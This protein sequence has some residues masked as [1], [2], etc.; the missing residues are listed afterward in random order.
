[1]HRKKIALI[2]GGQVGST[3]ALLVT[4]K[5]L[6]NTVIIDLPQY[7]NQVKGKALDIM[8]LRPHDAYDVNLS[9]TSNYAEI[10]GADVVVVTAGIPRTPQMNRKDLLSVNLK[11]IKKVATQV[12][13]YTPEAFVVIATNPVDAMTHAF[14][15]FS[16]FPKQ[17]VIGL[18]GALDTGR[19]QNF[20]A[21]ETGISV[22]DVSCLVMGGHGPTMVPIVRTATVGGIP[23]T[24]LLS[25]EKIAALVKRTREAGTEIVNLLGTGSAYFSS[26]A[27]ITEMVEAHMLDKKRVIASS[28][29]CEGEYGV[30][31][32][33]IGVPCVIGAHG[34]E[35][36]IE[37]KL[38]DDESK[39]FYQDLESIKE[40]IAE[41]QL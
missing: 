29:L 34:V 19:F 1:M 37:F 10:I 4:Q 23:L 6:G 24:D 31:G 13:K 27:S 40:T 35:R 3:V 33:F 21:M 28:V 18:S 38:A 26:A 5:E 41:A 22:K 2:G 9:G 30:E 39:L 32:Y 15:K 25:A 11:I 14:H 17:R 36:I 12:K 8:A 16:G 7:E 20:I